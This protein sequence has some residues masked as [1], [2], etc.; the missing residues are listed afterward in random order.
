MCTHSFALENRALR[1]AFLR[2]GVRSPYEKYICNDLCMEECNAPVLSGPPNTTWVAA[3]S[4]RAMTISAN[5]DKTI[6]HASKHVVTKQLAM[7]H[8]ALA[9]MTDP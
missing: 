7:C 2:F 8:L 3:P 1:T 9:S 5:G 6:N 4:V